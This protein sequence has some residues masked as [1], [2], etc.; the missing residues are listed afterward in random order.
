MPIKFVSNRFLIMTNSTRK[1]FLATRTYKM[2]LS[3]VMQTNFR[4]VFTHGPLQQF[5]TVL[6]HCKI[7]QSI[8]TNQTKYNF[9]KSDN[10]HTYIVSYLIN[11]FTLLGIAKS[12][13]LHV[14]L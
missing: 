13:S 1:N 5:V 3:D 2:A 11:T 10:L 9:S 8:V 12:T 6:L 7:H 14:L 4:S